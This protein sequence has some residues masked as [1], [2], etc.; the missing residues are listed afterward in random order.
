MTFDWPEPDAAPAP[1]RFS[2]IIQAVEPETLPK[3]DSVEW[4]ILPFPDSMGL[5]EVEIV[6]THDAILAFV[7]EEWGDEDPDWFASLTDRMD[8]VFPS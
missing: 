7:L 1:D 4:T 8:V 5:P 2:L 3:V 6:G